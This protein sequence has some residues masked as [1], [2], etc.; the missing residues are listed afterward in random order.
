MILYFFFTNL[1]RQ[2]W[3]GPWLGNLVGLLSKCYFASC[4]P[5][6]GGHRGTR[7]GTNKDVVLGI[8]DGEP[9]LLAEI[10]KTTRRCR[11]RST[12]GLCGKIPLRLESTHWWYKI[13]VIIKSQF[14]FDGS[15]LDIKVLK[16]CSVRQGV[17]RVSSSLHCCEGHFL[18]SMLCPILMR[19]HWMDVVNS[20]CITPP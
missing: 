12:H 15:M 2:Y 1:W 8:C 18:P 17:V 3:S 5:C 6:V 16:W 7:S 11:N 13:F 9:G 20:S 10:K 19:F 4:S 14:E